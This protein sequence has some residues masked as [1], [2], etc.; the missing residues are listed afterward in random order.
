MRPFLI[1]AGYLIGSIP[2]A[3]IIA[4]LVTGGDLRQMGSG[5]V[6]VM[7]TALSVAR[8]A[9][10]L[11][12]LAEVAKGMGAVWLARTVGG[13]DFTAALTLGAALVGTRWSIWL[14]G[15]GGR[16]NT[17]GVAGLLLISWLSLVA[18]L[19]LWLLVRRLTHSNFTAT[20]VTMIVW[21]LLAGLVM[22][23]WWPLPC[24]AVFS[25][26]FLSTHRKETDDHLILKSQ[27]SGV[28]AFLRAPPRKH[29]NAHKFG[30]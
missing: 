23:V 27:W 25:L 26:L 16:G 7:N 6:G 1:P 5:N 10:L 24:G 20:R 19:A 18:S 13:D 3:W 15:A 11:A 22:Q 8:W 4:R 2:V 12:F 30:E 29:D 17:L 14:R 9:G 21:P 28:R